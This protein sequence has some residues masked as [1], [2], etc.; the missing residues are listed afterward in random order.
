MVA[1][2]DARD[3]PTNLLD[4]S[5]SLVPEDGRAARLGGAVD[6]VLIRVAH[7]ARVQP[8]EHLAWPGLGELELRHRHRSTGPLEDRRANPHALAGSSGALCSSRSCSIGMW[9]RIRWPGSTS[10]SGG[11][12][13]S[14]I[15]PTFR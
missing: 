11:S 10:T 12:S 2:R 4:H 14:Q 9:Q 15:S 8:D 3:A 6:R 7:A 13:S 1:G 5:R